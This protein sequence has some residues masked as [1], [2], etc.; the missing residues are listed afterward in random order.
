MNTALFGWCGAVCPKF[1]PGA[2]SV[3][4]ASIGVATALP[5]GVD[6]FNE[7]TFSTGLVSGFTGGVSPDLVSNQLSQKTAHHALVTGGVGTNTDGD[8]I[9]QRL[10]QIIGT[11]Q[12]LAQAAVIG[13]SS[14]TSVNV[15]VDT[16]AQDPLW[17]LNVDPLGGPNAQNGGVINQAITDNL[18]GVAGASDVGSYGQLFANTD[19]SVSNA[20]VPAL[21]PGPAPAYVANSGV[22]GTSGGNLSLP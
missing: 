20:I 17:L 13:A 21:V 8:F 5:V 11:N 10:A 14:G 1:V 3:G 18:G 22:I 12:T 9:D 15:S 7:A 16:G 2:G 19:V 4:A 6:N